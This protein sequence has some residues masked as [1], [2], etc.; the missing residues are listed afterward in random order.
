[1]SLVCLTKLEIRLAP[2]NSAGSKSN[3]EFEFFDGNESVGKETV[4]HRLG[5]RYA[6]MRAFLYFE[7]DTGARDRDFSVPRP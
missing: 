1:M 5:L 7:L 4:P 2:V 6:A 3:L